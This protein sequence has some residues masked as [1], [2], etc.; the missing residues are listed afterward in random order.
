MPLESA[1]ASAR[2]IAPHRIGPRG[3]P[4]TASTLPVARSERYFVPHLPG[5]YSKSRHCHWIRQ[6]RSPSEAGSPAGLGLSGTWPVH[7]P[8]NERANG[9]PPPGKAMWQPAIRRKLP[10]FN[11]ARPAMADHNLSDGMKDTRERAL[12]ASGVRWHGG[13]LTM[14][15]MPIFATESAQGDSVRVRDWGDELAVTAGRMRP[16]CLS[17]ERSTNRTRESGSWW[18]WESGLWDLSW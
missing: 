16:H 14:R 12:L 18:K 3:R 17:G 5:A 9:L 7:V 15:K 2:S 1:E 6:E 4:A 13:C 8:C 10:S 11:W